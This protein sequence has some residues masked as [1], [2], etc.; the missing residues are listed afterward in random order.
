MSNDDSREIFP[1]VVLTRSFAHYMAEQ[2]NEY[3]TWLF[4]TYGHEAH[5]Y[6]IDLINV[7]RDDA[8]VIQEQYRYFL[9]QTNEPTTI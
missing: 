1:R 7:S 5:Q 6:G 4:D 8:T 9:Q 3:T 2:Y